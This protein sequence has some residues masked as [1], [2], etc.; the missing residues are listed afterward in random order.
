M[1]RNISTTAPIWLK[2]E[3]ELLSLRF[4]RNS[5]E[6]ITQIFLLA[7]IDNG[8]IYMKWDFFTYWAGCFFPFV[9]V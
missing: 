3:S 6:F 2:R 9:N 8:I 7:G 4:K 1:G 5:R